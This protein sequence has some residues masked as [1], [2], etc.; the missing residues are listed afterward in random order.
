MTKPAKP[1]RR[2]VI[3]AKAKIAKAKAAEVIAAIHA[4]EVAE[5]ER[6]FVAMLAAAVAQ[7]RS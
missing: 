6:A 2:E 3:E 7:A 5:E 1:T 4:K